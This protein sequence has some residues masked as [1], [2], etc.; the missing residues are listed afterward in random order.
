[1]EKVFL[2]LI[3]KAKKDKE[4]LAVALFGSYARKE[5]YRDIDVALILSENKFKKE[6]SKIRLDYLSNS[7][8][9]LDIH[10]FQQLPVYIRV[11]ILKEGKFILNKNEGLMYE[12]AFQ[13]IKEFGD[14]KEIYESYIENALK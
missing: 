10:V 5:D 13:T 6:M 9:R 12:L 2:K 7:D 14:F 4:I 3:K 11:K 8:S 1:M